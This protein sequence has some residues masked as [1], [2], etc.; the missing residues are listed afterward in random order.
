MSARS[1]GYGHKIA[2]VD[3]DFDPLQLEQ[4]S[5]SIELTCSNGTLPSRP[6][7]SRADGTLTLLADLGIDSPIRFI[8]RPTAPYRFRSAN[9]MHWRLISH[10]TL[11]HHSLL[12]GAL[13]ALREMLTLY[14]LP[15]SVIGQRQIDS[16]VGLAHRPTT[17]WIKFERGATLVHG[18]EVHLQISEE[19]F[20]GSS[21]HLFVSV[22]D[23]FLGLYVQANSFTE[24]LVSNQHGKELMRC[25]PRTGQLN[26]A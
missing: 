12:Q 16:I 22:I 11:N 23:R 1:P 3:V 17:A 24:L 9:G 4:A 19:G 21:L 13:P 10:L 15:Q 2:F 8:R 20:V 25:K 5:V 7:F 6:E 26:L 14:N 18:V